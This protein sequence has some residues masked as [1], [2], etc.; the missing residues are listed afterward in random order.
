MT[1]HTSR[2]S[3]LSYFCPKFTHR[4]QTPWFSDGASSDA[5]W[6]HF[7]E[8]F[9]HWRT[10]NPSRDSSL[11]EVSETCLLSR[12]SH[13]LWLHWKI[14]S[15]SLL[16]WIFTVTDGR[17]LLWSRDDLLH[18]YIHSL[19][20]INDCSRQVVWNKFVAFLH[21]ILCEFIEY[22]W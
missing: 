18:L 5:R 9:G 22:T 15:S 10:R 21:L 17:F 3:R 20:E 14:V 1:Q 7:Q 6:I 16:D 19:D 11:S 12:I 2:S 8:L 13:Q 4:D